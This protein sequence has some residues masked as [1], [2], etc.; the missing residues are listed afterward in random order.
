M[1]ICMGRSGS[2]ALQGRWLAGLLLLQFLTGL[3]NVVL[4]WPLVA[5]VMHTGGAAALL[6]VL[7]WALASTQVLKARQHAVPATFAISS[8]SGASA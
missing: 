4:G 7:V 6:V 1:A 2:L 8:S 3:S 5:A